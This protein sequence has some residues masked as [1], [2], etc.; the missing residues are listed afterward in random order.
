[1]VK[2][3]ETRYVNFNSVHLPF[4]LSPEQLAAARREIEAA[5]LVIV[6]GGVITFDDRSEE[7]T[8]ELQS[9]VDLVCRL[10]L[11]KKNEY[12]TSSMTLTPT[13]RKTRAGAP[14]TVT[15]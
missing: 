14:R 5:G 13:S 7:H 9:R 11:E 15:P 2:A 8:S 12:T 4:E 3:L 1:M 10:L 6:G